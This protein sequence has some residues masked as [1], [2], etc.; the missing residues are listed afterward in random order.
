MS[1]AN[2]KNIEQMK[3]FIEVLMFAIDEISE[4]NP[5]KYEIEPQKGLK[6]TNPLHHSKR[7]YKSTDN[8]VYK[9][10]DRNEL[11]DKEAQRLELGILYLE[12][13]RI[14]LSEDGRCL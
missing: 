12:P 5:D 4:Y 10:Y 11:D 8:M 1:E 6:L 14:E 9:L 2:P 3:Q 13:R 7:V